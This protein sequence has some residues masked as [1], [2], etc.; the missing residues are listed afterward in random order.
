MRRHDASGRR[1]GLTLAHLR[2]SASIAA[3]DSNPNKQSSGFF[4]EQKKVAM[5]D[6][7]SPDP[8]DPLPSTREFYNV[9]GCDEV[10]LT[11]EESAHFREFGFIIKRG[12]I[13]QADLQPFIDLWWEQP[14]VITAR[15]SPDDL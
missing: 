2:C 10:G 11:P 14:P 7:A 8:L 1:L 15:V 6:G 13:P 9:K 5:K 3:A 12:L 4:A